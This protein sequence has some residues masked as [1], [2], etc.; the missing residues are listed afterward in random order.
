MTSLNDM[1]RA[2]K[3]AEPMFNAVICEVKDRM[4]KLVLGISD[5]E[6]DDEYGSATRFV[7]GQRDAMQSVLKAIPEAEDICVDAICELADMLRDARLSASKD[8]TKA[9]QATAGQPG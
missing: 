5:P 6:V 2:I 7:E 8:E 9:S 3:I 4:A 1:Q